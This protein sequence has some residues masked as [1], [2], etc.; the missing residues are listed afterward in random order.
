[1]SGSHYGAEDDALLKELNAY[2]S[3]EYIDGAFKFV[4]KPHSKSIRV[5]EDFDSKCVPDVNFIQKCK[6]FN[7][8]HAKVGPMYICEN[9]NGEKVV[10]NDD[11][12]SN[13][14]PTS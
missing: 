11:S 13:S 2:I 10:Q 4:Y 12:N 7:E 5:P 8:E 9:I 1:M 14:S 3:N 6:S